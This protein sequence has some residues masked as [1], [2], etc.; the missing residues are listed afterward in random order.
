MIYDR[1]MG[2]GAGEIGF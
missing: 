1:K 2:R